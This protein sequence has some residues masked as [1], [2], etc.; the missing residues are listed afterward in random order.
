[1]KKSPSTKLEKLLSTSAS[2]SKLARAMTAPLRQIRNYTGIARSAFSS[3]GVCCICHKS[4]EEY[5]IYNENFEL[6]E[7]DTKERLFIACHD[8]ASDTAEELFEISKKTIKEMPLLINSPNPFIAYAVK[9]R[10]KNG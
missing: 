4:E 7:I 6:P 1:M 10:L 5:A 2:R 9:E 3:K 8:C